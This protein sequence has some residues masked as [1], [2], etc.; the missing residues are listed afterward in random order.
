M[1]NR[2]KLRGTTEKVFDLGLTNKQIFDAS[3]HTANRTWVLPDSN[4]TNTYVLT[5]NGSGTLSW[6]A[7]ATGTV[8]SV[9]GTAARITS[10]GGATP[11][12]DI[13]ATYVGQ[14]SIT[15]LGT[16]TTGT[17]TG[18][19]IAAINGGTAQTTYA[20]GDTLYASA[21]NTLSKLAVG[22]VGQVLTLAG[23]VPT[24]AT[25]TTGTVTSVSGTAARI[26]STGGATPVID[27]D[28]TYVGQT[29]IT[30]LG[31]ITTGVWNGTAIANANLA[32][33]TITVG[34]TAIAL[35]AS[36]TSL[37]GIT[38]ISMNNQLTSTLATG[39]AP[40][41]I[42]STT[43]VSNL[44]V[45][46][47]G[48]ADVLTTARTINTVSFDGSANIVVTAAAGT[49][50]GAT[51]NATVT[52][53]SL[54]SVGT[55]TTG[56]WTGTTIAA[57]NGGTGQTVYAVG[58]ILAADTT[59]TLSK[60]AD[61]ATGNALISGGVG[62]LPSYGK[63][64]LTT[65]VSGTLAATSGGTAQSTYTTGDI[66]YSSATNTL[67]KLGIGS[68]N[69]V[70]TVS[71]G[72]PAWSAGLLSI[73]SAKTL[74]VTNSLTL[75]GTD[76]TTMTFPVASASIGYINIPQNSKSAAYT[77]VLADQG[78]HIF[79]PAADTNARTFTIDSNANVAYAIGT[80]ITFIN[81]TANLVTIA[82]TSD[83]LTWCPS[84]TTGSRTLAQYGVATA[85]KVTTTKWY[86]T[87]V[88]LT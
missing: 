3:G 30:T 72:I 58:D 12:I 1:S 11:V 75:S 76:S 52:G 31:T 54:T 63:I 77:T 49:L 23:G 22:T 16:I 84:G 79:H 46:T 57:I 86:L 85:T 68:T 83:T 6:A 17:W 35:G 43:R 80:T 5:T 55:I 15:T 37:G 65:H 62:V 88:G 67:S 7:P 48:T 78:K 32:N 13:D 60:V 66:L 69:A 81:E 33:S 29:S 34:T 51:L 41:V 59:T 10:T 87:G 53:S 28:A 82:I 24:W 40:F 44:N 2:I 73:T 71:G 64:G 38:T 26:T 56:T 19:A 50:T 25:P 4:G 61:V 27:I 8:T 9:S 45:A 21:A 74:T 39:T 14:T 42:A 18:T 36:S 20:T 47:A 70:L